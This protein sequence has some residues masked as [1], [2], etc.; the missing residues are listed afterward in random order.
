ML[1]LTPV[2]YL[3]IFYLARTYVSVIIA[4]ILGQNAQYLVGK[5]WNQFAKGIVRFAL[6]TLPA[7]AINSGLK[8]FKEIL[9]IRFR[10]RLSEYVHNEYLRG[11]NFYKACNLGSERIDNA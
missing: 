2:C 5:K 7:S 3:F 4:D 6:I 10:V 8:Y 11:V 1:N 9:V